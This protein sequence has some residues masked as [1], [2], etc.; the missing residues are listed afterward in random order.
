VP[1]ILPF[2]LC[3]RLANVAVPGRRPGASGC[4]RVTNHSGSAS[5]GPVPRKP[6]ACL[7]LRIASA[8]TLDSTRPPFLPP[9]PQLTLT[10]SR[11]RSSLRSG[12]PQTAATATS[13]AQ[14]TMMA[15]CR[16]TRHSTFIPLPHPVIAQSSH[17]E[18]TTRRTLPIR[19]A[20]PRRLN[21]LP[22]YPPAPQS[23]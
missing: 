18:P 8:I 9:A 17:R 1:T 5:L 15:P 14:P 10:P 4:C 3:R 21:A 23:N 20:S 22:L 13:T 2:L 11:H 19:G 6:S 7:R 16:H 12:R